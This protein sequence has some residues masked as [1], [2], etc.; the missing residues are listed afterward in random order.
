MDFR[1]IM[2]DAITLF[3]IV[4]PIGGIPFFLEI[5]K[6]KSEKEKTHIAYLTWVTGVV[7]LAGFSFAGQAMLDLVFHITLNDIKIAGGALLLVIS[8]L[9]IVKN[10]GKD[11]HHGVSASE[12]SAVP[13]AF[14]LLVGPGS[15]VTSVIIFQKQ[16][17]L[18]SMVIILAVSVCMWATLRY[19]EPLFK[20]IGEMGTKVFSKVMSVIL[21]AIAVRFIMTGITSYLK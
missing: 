14:P 13:L 3:A 9:N 7:L 2:Q 17:F 5:T 11:E 21:A 16:G 6:N 15:L 20:F 12:L 4:N 8:I 10:T 18:L 19:S 1:E